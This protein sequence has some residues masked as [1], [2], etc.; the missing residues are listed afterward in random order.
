MSEDSVDAASPLIETKQLVE[1]SPEKPAKIEEDTVTFT[2]QELMQ[3][4]LKHMREVNDLK[5]TIVDLKEAQEELIAKH[6]SEIEKKDD[7]N[8]DLLIELRQSQAQVTELEAELVET[9]E[10]LAVVSTKLIQVQHELFET[11]TTPAWICSSV[12]SLKVSFSV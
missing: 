8:M 5:S 12:Q 3:H 9:K 7:E 11:K 2:N 10:E 1:A 4:E 6:E